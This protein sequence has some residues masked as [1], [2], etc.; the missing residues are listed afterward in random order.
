LG[1][2]YIHT[3]VF[4]GL[5]ASRTSIE[6]HEAGYFVLSI[7]PSVARV[8]KKSLWIRATWRYI[9]CYVNTTRTS[10]PS[11]CAHERHHIL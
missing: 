1:H 10:R 6:F 9:P 3:Y 2:F 11:D 4:T 7:E 8:P 5:L